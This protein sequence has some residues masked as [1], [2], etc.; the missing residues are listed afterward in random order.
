MADGSGEDDQRQ[1]QRGS[2]VNN[3]G[4][5]GC[6]WNPTKEQISVLEGL[7]RQ[8][9][10]TPTADQIQQITERLRVY[11]H[12]EGKNVFY[13]FQN[14][15]ARQRQKPYY[16][17]NDH[18]LYHHHQLPEVQLPPA[19]PQRYNQS[20]QGEYINRH[21]HHQETLDLFPIHPT[22]FLQRN[23]SNHDDQNNEDED[24]N[25]NSAA[26]TSTSS[27]NTTDHHH[28]HHHNHAFFDFFCRN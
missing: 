17:A 23:S 26:A 9:L 6:R 2:S 10:R 1:M 13:W 22:G 18:S 21:P 20:K 25:P 3:N 5:G 28:H 14:H 8:G 4:G 16:I 15:K 19:Q 7:Y 27:G 24:E 11:G 12:I